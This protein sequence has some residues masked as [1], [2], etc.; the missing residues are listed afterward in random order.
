MNHFAYA[1]EVDIKTSRV[2]Y[3]VAIKKMTIIDS[4]VNKAVVNGTRIDV[5]NSIVTTIEV[6]GDPTIVAIVFV[7]N[8]II[9]NVIFR[10]QGYLVYGPRSRPP[11][12]VQYQFPKRH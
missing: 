6:N 3:A 1:T 7:N 8:S 12:N 11:L 4:T 9:N 10:T 5:V 2:G